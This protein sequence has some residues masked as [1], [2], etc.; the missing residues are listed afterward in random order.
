MSVPGFLADPSSKK[1]GAYELTKRVNS[2]KA[3]LEEFD[4][5]GIA[6]HLESIPNPTVF[7]SLQPSQ[8]KMSGLNLEIPDAIEAAVTDGHIVIL[9][10]ASRTG[11]TTIGRYWVEAEETTD[12]GL[13][14][15][16]GSG[17]VGNY[18]Q[19]IRRLGQS[20]KVFIDEMPT[21]PE[22]INSVIQLATCGARVCVSTNIVKVIDL[23][24][25]LTEGNV[26]V[27]TI[28]IPLQTEAQLADYI[29]R[30]LQL[31]ADNQLVVAISNISGGCPTVANL[32]CAEL[33]YAIADGIEEEISIESG[34]FAR[35]LIDELLIR[36]H[37]YTPQWKK[38]Q[39]SSPDQLR[40]YIPDPLL[41]YL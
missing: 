16:L 26:N 40:Q 31:P 33:I 9:S 38:E 20:P 1:S 37:S 36:M 15:D 29:S 12:R 25:A 28:I 2:A 27:K 6:S 4:Y 7:D 30:V 23:A 41:N 17:K 11:K 5:E 3:A 24:K 35:F 8:F 14:I 39:D 19:E 21:D 22:T 10:G 18:S 32:V 13:F 34:P